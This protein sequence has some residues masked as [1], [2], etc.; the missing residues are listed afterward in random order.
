MN[1]NTNSIYR[2][3]D[4]IANPIDASSKLGIDSEIEIT[5]LD[6][7]ISGQLF[8]LSTD[9]IDASAQIQDPC[10]SRIAE[11]LSSFALIPSE[12]ISNEP[13]DLLPSKPYFSKLEPLTLTN[14]GS[15]PKLA[16]YGT[17]CKLKQGIGR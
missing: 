14:K 17:G 9:M 2:F 10:S 8:S 4:E 3:G 13:G 12:G 1:I 15:I 7:D 11:N 5:S 16:S 6:I